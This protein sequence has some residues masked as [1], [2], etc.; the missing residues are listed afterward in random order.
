MDFLGN[1]DGA[2]K[3]IN[4]W[5][6]QQTRDK[7]RD[8]LHPGQIESRTRLVLCNAIYFKGDWAT[9]FDPKKTR[10]QPFFVSADKSVTVPMMSGEVKLLSR[11]F[12]GV[13]LFELPYQG[14]DLAM[15][16]LLPDARDGLAALEQQLNAVVLQEWL[17]ALGQ[18]YQTEV[19]VIL[20]KFKLNCRLDL[21]GDLK[22]MGMPSAFGLRADFSG[23]DGSSNLGIDGVVHQ[24]F[25]DVNEEGTEAAAATAVTMVGLSISRPLVVFRA[26]HPFLFLIV[27]RHTG[28]ILFLGRVTDPSN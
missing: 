28:T 13:T 26:D 15:V 27:G 9:Q 14:N 18:S 11:Q 5:V 24:A 21:V 16:V 17:M 7:I 10:P 20:P 19:P 23:M 25:V 1:P 6:E 3:E 12:K 4:T 8:L 22:A 2:R